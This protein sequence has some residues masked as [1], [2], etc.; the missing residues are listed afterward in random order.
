MSPFVVVFGEAFKSFLP[1]CVPDVH[2]DLK[3]IFDHQGALR[4]F[5]ANSWGYVGLGRDVFNESIYQSCFS[6]IGL[7]DQDN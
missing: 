4:E 2:L 5:N 1:C 6:H 3:F 7:A